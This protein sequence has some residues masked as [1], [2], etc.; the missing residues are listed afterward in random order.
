MKTT[1]CLLLAVLATASFTAVAQ[2]DRNRRGA[3]IGVG[4]GQF[5]LD[6]DN[7]GDLEDA[8]ATVRDS[9]DNV[10]KLFVGYRFTRWL[11][12]EAAYVDLGDPGDSF[13]ASGSDGNYRIGMSGFAPALIGSIPVGPIEIFGKVGRYYYDVDTRIE[14]DSPGSD[15]STSYSRDDTM[16]GAGISGVVFRR[17]ELRGEYQKIEIEDAEDSDAVWLSAAWRF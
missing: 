7:L 9:D 4:A 6:V 5:N 2:D 13:D 15:I 3:F 8:A 11:S 10:W 1:H 12:I 17:L 16:Y 14:F